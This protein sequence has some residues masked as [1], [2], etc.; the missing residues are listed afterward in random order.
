MRR[1]VFPL[2]ALVASCSLPDRSN[3][4]DPQNAP[5]VR[6]RV[7]DHTDPNGNCA[8]D[9]DANWPDVVTV[10]RGRCIA[11][12]ARDTI[13]PQTRPTTD[14][15]LDGRLLFT[16]TID[17][18]EGDLTILGEDDG[19]GILPISPELGRTF[20]ART[21]LD[22]GVT[23]RAPDGGV[24]RGSASLIVINRRPEAVAGPAR[25]LPRTGY[26]WGSLGLQTV[27]DA[28]RSSDA[29]GDPLEYCWLLP[30]AAT[31]SCSA[32]PFLVTTIPANEERFAA[33]LVVTD[34]IDRSP[35][36]WATAHRGH[37]IWITDNGGA[38]LERLAEP[39]PTL[40]FDTYINYV[41]PLDLA[42]G[43]RG[44]AVSDASGFRIL[45]LPSGS[46]TP[47]PIADP[48]G[49]RDV[50]GDR[51]GN[52]WLVTVEDPYPTHWARRRPLEPAAP[53]GLGAETVAIATESSD[54]ACVE[55]RAAALA[56][57]SSGALWLGSRVFGDLRVIRTDGSIQV[58][59]APSTLPQDAVCEPGLYDT[60]YF[61]S[62]AARPGTDEVWALR[63]HTEPEA[64]APATLLVYSSSGALAYAVD[65]DGIPASL[66]FAGFEEVWI[67]FALRGLVLVDAEILTSGLP[68]ASSVIEEFPE[69]VGDVMKGVDP[70]TGSLAASI[71]RQ[72]QDYN[73]AISADR[74]VTE[75]GPNEP[76][77]SMLFLDGDG[78]SW[79]PSATYDAL[80]A[81]ETSRV[82]Q[83]A[84]Q[85]NLI[86]PGYPEPAHDASTGWM[87]V[88]V[89]LGPFTDL[90][91]FGLAAVGLDGSIAR[92]SESL[93]YETGVVEAF[94][95]ASSL[96]AAN[97]GRHLLVVTSEPP[98]RLLLL[99]LASQP[100]LVVAESAD[101]ALVGT[102]S[103]SYEQYVLAAPGAA[104]LGWYYDPD[105]SILRTFD[106]D[107]VPSGAVFTLPSTEAYYSVEVA[108][109]PASN[110]ACVVS[111][112]N[113]PGVD[114]N[115]HVRMIAAD[116]SGST[117]ILNVANN[118]AA[119]FDVGF[120]DLSV[121]T[122]TNAAGEE[123][124]WVATQTDVTAPTFTTIAYSIRSNGTLR[125][126]RSLPANSLSPV[127]FAL[128]IDEAW[129][130]ST[131]LSGVS[132]AYYRQRIDL[133]DGD[134][135]LNTGTPGTEFRPPFRAQ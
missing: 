60:S 37:A 38:T 73:L 77:R 17:T 119:P 131:V 96:H 106:S 126:S 128:T 13:D 127:L 32:D 123:G 70:V 21:E 95:R 63:V 121:S 66:A 82:D 76:G 47:A 34:G 129:A 49:L 26:P 54:D 108:L 116:G 5:F 33:R 30:G 19:S 10:A 46:P 59:S 85:G 23:V 8:A 43:A 48:S 39:G 72:G 122:W 7:I 109:L 22:V 71:Y 61:A 31:E 120:P 94:P 51:A 16:Y 110:R 42:N 41:N 98:R 81:L 92:I 25:R 56:V 111:H 118:A 117:S 90:P 40:A 35:V 83:L 27:L 24:G 113:G 12:D 67:D 29:D 52:V 9:L 4:Q 101:P 50:V 87:W 28:S 53:G 36:K 14:V 115:T 68:F 65:L 88:V 69:F 1:L 55:A 91:P 18:G 102:E 100:P 80:T 84:L 6:V 132:P 93:E 134:T 124:C 45:P 20:P 97:D 58:L 114:V 57:D 104:F 44:I 112:G 103:T 2:L 64:E 105:T 62:I 133:I 79:F 3:P 107:L 11:I 75:T 15:P 74:V 78:T 125:G 99:D 135:L 86:A 130:S 89:S